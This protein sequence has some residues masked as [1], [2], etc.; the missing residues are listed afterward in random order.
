MSWKSN[1]ILEGKKIVG[2]SYNNKKFIWSIGRQHN[3]NSE[4]VIY[5]LQCD[6]DYCKKNYIG[7]T[8]DLRERIYQHVGYARNKM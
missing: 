1:Y 3:C 2:K 8:Q 4:N 6:K 7:M 5:L